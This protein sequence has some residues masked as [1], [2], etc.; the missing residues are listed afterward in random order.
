M[1]RKH[2]HC[3]WLIKVAGDNH[4]RHT[5]YMSIHICTHRN[6]HMHISLMYTYIT[7]MCIHEYICLYTY[8]LMH[9]FT[10]TEEHARLMIQREC[11]GLIHHSCCHKVHCQSGHDLVGKQEAPTYASQQSVI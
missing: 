5:I 7:C 8:M 11:W 2:I 1:H 10:Y 6:C 9:M 3:D 4:D